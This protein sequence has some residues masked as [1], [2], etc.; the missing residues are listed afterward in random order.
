MND[1]ITA[2]DKAPIGSRCKICDIDD[3]LPIKGRLNEL[4]FFKGANIDKLQVGFSGSPIACR[5]CGAVIAV[6]AKDAE[7]IIVK[8]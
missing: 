4:G 8:M 7:R 6:R 5:V 2:L 3:S 1:F